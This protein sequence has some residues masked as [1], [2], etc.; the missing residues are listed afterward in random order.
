MRSRYILVGKKLLPEAEA[1]AILDRHRQTGA[2]V[3]VVPDIVEPFVSPVDGT[4]LSSR[5]AVREHNRRN[6]V[7]DVGNDAA[8]QEPSKPKCTARVRRSDLIAGCF[9]TSDLT[10]R[11]SRPCSLEA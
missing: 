10:C 7:A 8:F 6:S 1:R 2:G 9:A 5:A 4:L 3:T 11:P